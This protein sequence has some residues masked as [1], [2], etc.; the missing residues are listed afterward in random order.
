M[1]YRYEVYMI[2][3]DSLSIKVI[4]LLERSNEWCNILF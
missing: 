3:E 4:E 2:S 1:R